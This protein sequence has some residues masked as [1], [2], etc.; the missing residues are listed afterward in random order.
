M[1]IQILVLEKCGVELN[2]KCIEGI[3]TDGIKKAYRE[4]RT[5]TKET[6]VSMNTGVYKWDDNMKSLFKKSYEDFKL[7]VNLPGVNKENIKAKGGVLGTSIAMT[8]FQTLLANMEN[9][10]EDKNVAEVS[11]NRVFELD[12]NFFNE[13]TGIKSDDLKKLL[14]SHENSVYAALNTLLEEWDN[15]YMAVFKDSIIK[16]NDY[17]ERGE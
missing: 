9:I 13:L 2:E 10:E 6:A 1:I 15:L 7:M 4:V 12:F 8:I 16:L 5:P 14:T 11:L 3:F 17:V